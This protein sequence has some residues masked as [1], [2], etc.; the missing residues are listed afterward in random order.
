MLFK[1]YLALTILTALYAVY[2]VISYRQKKAMIKK[3]AV[4]VGTVRKAHKSKTGLKFEMDKEVFKVLA[5][6]EIDGK[7]YSKSF[8][9][10]AVEGDY[11]EGQS[12][13]LI[14]DEKR[15]SRAVPTN[16][17]TTGE[18]EKS[19]LILKIFPIVLV[20]MVFIFTLPETLHMDKE[21]KRIHRIITN[22]V[23]GLFFGAYLCYYKMSGSYKK[24]LEK[25]PKAAKSSVASTSLLLLNCIFKVVMELFF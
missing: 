8:L 2:A 3:N 14:Y 5:D 9:I 12:I 25:N 10:S 24:D 23:F 13:E 18:L 17:D 4:T 6:Y 15:P 21:A 7:S 22:A 11:Y 1:I 19:I 20:L 16:Y